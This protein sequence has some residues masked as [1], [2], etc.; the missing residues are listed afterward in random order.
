MRW[1]SRLFGGRQDMAGLRAGGSGDIAALEKRLR[2]SGFP[3]HDAGRLFLREYY[4]L[5]LDVPI[6]EVDWIKGFVHF[7]PEMV[8]RFLE[9]SDV[10]RLAAL[11]PKSA[12]PI[13][14]TGGHTMFVFMDDEG[15]SYLLHMEWDLFAELA[16]TPTE[17][18]HVLCDGRN[19]R[20]DSQLL[21]EFGRPTGEIVREGDE[22][23]H[24]QLDQFPGIAPYL[25]LVSLSPARRPPTWRAM[26]RAAEQSMAPGYSP[27]SVTVSAGG[28][29][30]SKSGQ[31]FFVA[32]CENCLYVLSQSGIVVRSPVQGVRVGEV[33]A[34]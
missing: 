7:A 25:P 11:M 19:G 22:R 27:T 31:T 6:A 14:T 26:L 3:M 33:F 12:M 21:D 30:R 13:G 17:M 1:L 18:M 34:C 9:P 28:I 32:Q 24:W 2:K 20:V 16:S 29:F 15:R 8:L 4:G 23:R 5:S 10:P